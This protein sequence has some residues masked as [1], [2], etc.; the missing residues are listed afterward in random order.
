MRL[1][2]FFYPLAASC[3][4]VGGAYVMYLYLQDYTG[5]VIL[6]FGVS[7]VLAALGYI[8]LSFAFGSL[9]KKD[10]ALLPCGDRVLALLE[11]SQKQKR[12]KYRSVND[13][14]E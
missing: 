9:S 4:S 13:Q 2:T 10:I 7:L 5:S 3:I 12:K 14:E 8:A 1:S 6:Y 11:R